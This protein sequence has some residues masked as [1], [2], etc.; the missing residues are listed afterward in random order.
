MEVFY[1]KTNEGLITMGWDVVQIGLRHNLPV[2]DPF[3]TAKEVAKRMN[4]NVRLVYRNEYEYDKENNVVREVNGCELIELGKF[5][6]NNSNDYLKMTVSDY[7]AH[8]IQEI[9]GI[10]KLRQATFV[11]EWA[12]SILSDIEGD[13]FEL[14][15]IEDNDETLDIR[16]FKENVNLDV[17]ISGRCIPLIKTREKGMVTQLSDEDLSSSKDVWLQ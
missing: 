8:Q 3:A 13:P 10:D 9:A 12:D 6:V 4:R 11:G 17:C 16:I 2:H 14:Y 7:Q 1:Y 5:E 15:E